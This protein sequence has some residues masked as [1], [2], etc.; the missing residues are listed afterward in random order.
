MDF[1][2]NTKCKRSDE[3][4]QVNDEMMNVTIFPLRSIDGFCFAFFSFFFSKIKTLSLIT[5]KKRKDFTFYVCNIQFKN[6]LKSSV[7][8]EIFSVYLNFLELNFACCSF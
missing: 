8:L 4:N 6:D 1:Y 3:P 5:K 7:F 2:F